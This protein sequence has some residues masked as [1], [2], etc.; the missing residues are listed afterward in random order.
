MAE[1]NPTMAIWL[2]KQ[3]LD[4]SDKNTLEGGKVPIS[5]GVKWAEKG[6]E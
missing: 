4:Q 2:G 3:Y 5:I 1:N 6:P